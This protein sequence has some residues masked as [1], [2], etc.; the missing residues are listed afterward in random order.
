[1]IKSIHIMIILIMIGVSSLFTQAQSTD[2]A[3][4]QLINRLYAEGKLHGGILMAEGEQILLSQAWG[5]ADR[6]KGLVLTEDQQFYINSLN[7]MFTSVLI[8][9]MVEEGILALD[10][11]LSEHYP[12]FKHPRADDITIHHMLSHRTGL[13]DY[14][15]YQI[16]GQLPWD[17]QEAAL[18]EAVA[19]MDLE[20]E[21]GTMFHYSNSGYL[22][23]RLIIEK[24]RTTTYGNALTEWILEPLRMTH[25]SGNAKEHYANMPVY[26]S[27][28]GS[29]GKVYES[30]FRGEEVISTQRDL[31]RF[32][33]ALGSEKLLRKET[34]EL[35]F[36]PHSF[37]S[38]VPEGAWPPP[39]QNPY[40]Y[41]FSIMELPSNNGKTTRAV[42]HGG[43]GMGSNFAVRY[44][45]SK[46]I[47]IIWN[48]I[49]KDPILPEIFE[50]IAANRE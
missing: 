24:Y 13:P 23:L 39:H 27:Q 22:L 40:G 44:L 43:A 17:L 36:T 26:Y 37:P 42:A 12:E 32:M 5:V 14:V 33:L 41:G 16:R 45:E 35:M 21:P 29:A 49:Y 28:D 50:H 8:M 25:T 48:S 34:W 38:E 6:E 4:Q 20:F 9:Q 1:M 30:D 7:K 3:L 46:D 10:D 47:L 19:G 11:P 18:L 2:P 31:Y 15:W